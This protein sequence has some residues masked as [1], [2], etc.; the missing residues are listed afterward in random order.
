[1]RDI[2]KEDLMKS[3][4][5]DLN[6]QIADKKIEHRKQNSTFQ[7]NIAAFHE[8]VINKQNEII[9]TQQLIN[10]ELPMVKDLI[11]GVA[12]DVKSIEYG[13]DDDNIDKQDNFANIN[14]DNSYNMDM[15][16]QLGFLSLNDL[17]S[18]YIKKKVK[19]QYM[20]DYEKK[21]RGFLYTKEGKSNTKDYKDEFKKYREIFKNYF[22]NI[23]IHG[24]GISE[25]KYY[26]NGDD[27]VEKLQVLIGEGQAGNDNVSNEID[28]ILEKLKEEDYISEKEY[29][30]LVNNIL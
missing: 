5:N 27:L 24:H 22:H 25:Y 14:L 17:F 20:L 2:T 28:Q 15:I 12:S 11:D 6:K 7:E 19:L 18:K 13:L 26:K 29:L 1:M 10:Q 3:K 21:L 30:Q 16:K 4:L 23:G 8:P 9:S